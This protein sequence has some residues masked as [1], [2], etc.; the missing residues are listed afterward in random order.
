MIKNRKIIEI[1]TFL[2]QFLITVT[3]PNNKSL[4]KNFDFFREANE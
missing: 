4:Q 2:F 1:L 3:S